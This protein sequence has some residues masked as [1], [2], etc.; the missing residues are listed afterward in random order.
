MEDEHAARPPSMRT[1]APT[2]TGSTSVLRS[3]VHDRAGQRA[4]DAGDILDLGDDQLA[5][6]VN[7]AGFDAGNDVVCYRHV[8][9]HSDARYLPDCLGYQ[10]RSA[11][12]GLTQDVGLD[13]HDTSKGP[14]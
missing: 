7:R 6:L 2:R 1:T 13:H 12:L 9:G 4:G 8:L 5:K 11:N 3:D 10:R 14:R